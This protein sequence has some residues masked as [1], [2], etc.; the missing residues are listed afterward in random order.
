MGWP[1]PNPVTQL[2]Q[3]AT[4]RGRRKTRLKNP[5]KKP[6]KNV[7]GHSPSSKD[8]MKRINQE[9]TEKKLRRQKGVI[10]DKFEL[11]LV[12]KRGVGIWSGCNKYMQLSI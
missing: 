3:P 8:I 5:L 11:I 2:A 6:A 12:K 4:T 10:G 9:E 7:P 1:G